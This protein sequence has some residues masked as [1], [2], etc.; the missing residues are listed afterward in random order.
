MVSDVSH[1]VIRTHTHT[2][3]NVFA[4]KLPRGHFNVNIYMCVCVLFY[5][6]VSAVV[7]IVF[8]CTRFGVRECCGGVAWMPTCLLL[9]PADRPASVFF[10]QKYGREVCGGGGENIVTG[11]RYGSG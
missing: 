5:A 4:N 10:D 2:V 7:V 8:T 11:S 9:T 3:K 6:R 1:P